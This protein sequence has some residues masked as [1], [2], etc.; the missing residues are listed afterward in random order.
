L[1][2]MNYVTN[3][4]FYRLVLIMALPFSPAFLINI[5]CGLSRLSFKKFIV[6]VIIAKTSIVY[7]W[8]FVGKSFFDSIADPVILLR[9]GIL[10]VTAYAI[11]RIVNKKFDLK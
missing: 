6:A 2:F 11:S 9:I 8:G 7:F 4:S 1:K 3:I 10:L 5:L